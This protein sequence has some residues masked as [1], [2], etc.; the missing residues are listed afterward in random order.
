[1]MSSLQIS[2]IPPKKGAEHHNKRK[3]LKSEISKQKV[4]LLDG[5]RI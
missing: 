4:Y 3:Y 5:K 1:M 2:L